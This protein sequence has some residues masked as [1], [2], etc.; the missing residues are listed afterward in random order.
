MAFLTVAQFARLY[1]G[2]VL[3]ENLSDSGSPIA[4]GDLATNDNLLDILNM[5]SEMI[6]A[7]ALVGKRYT[8][9]QLAALAAS[10]DS[11]YLLR[12]LTADLAFA[13][14]LARRGRAAADLDRLAP[15]RAWAL[16]QLDLLRT[17]T[18]LFPGIDSGDHPEAGLPSQ[19]NLNATTQT[20]RI[21]T[22]TAKAGRLF[23]WSCDRQLPPGGDCGC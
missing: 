13:L 15:S 19:A 3:R 22:F 17:G 14:V 8:P 21:T 2:R 5:A 12:R 11:G 4:S 10:N 20:N 6:S 1:D 7:A 23:P 16:Q 9:A 18:H